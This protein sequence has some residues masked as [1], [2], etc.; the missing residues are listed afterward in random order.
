MKGKYV[1]IAVFVLFSTLLFFLFPALYSVADN[2][3]PTVT[4]ITPSSGITGTVVDVTN[5]EG[6]GFWG[7]PEVKIAR[8]IASISTG[9]DYTIGVLDEG[10]VEAVGDNSNGQ[11]NVSGWTGIKAIS[12]KG[13]NTVGLK[14]DG[15]VVA[16]GQNYYNRNKIY[17]W[18]GISAVSAGG[19]H[20]VGLRNDGTVVA[21]GDNA[22]G[23][24]NVS[25]WTDIIAVSSGFYHT[26]GL[27]EDGTVVAVGHNTYG[28][29]NVSSWTDIIA[30]SSGIYNTVGLK[31]DGTAVAVGWNNYGQCNVSSW[32][33]ITAV[34]AGG[35][36]TI[37]LKGDGTAVAVG[38]NNYGQCDISGWTDIMAVSSGFFHT[39]GLKEDGTVLA[40]G[41]NV[42]GQCN[43]SG[44]TKYLNA[45]DVAVLSPTQITCTLDLMGAETGPW[46]VV[47]ANED[48]KSGTL[49]G[50]FDIEHPAPTVTGID[51]GDGNNDETVHILNLTGTNFRDKATVRITRTGQADITATSVNVVSDTQITCDLDLTGAQIGQWKVVVLNDDGKDGSLDNGFTVEYH[52][53]AISS[54]TPDHGDIT[55]ITS[56]T[57]LHGSGFMIG[58]TVRLTR[59]GQ[60]DIVADFVTVVSDI[61]ITCDLDLTG[62]ELGLWNVVVENNDGMS[63]I[64]TNGFFA[65]G[66]SLGAWGQNDGGQ[67]NFPRGNDYRAIEAG[68]NHSLALKEDGSLV[69][70]GSNNYGQCNVPAGIYKAAAAGPANN[71]AI[72]SDGSLVGWGFNMAGQCT[73]PAGYDYVAVTAGGNHSV[74]IKADGSLV[75]WGD[76][77]LGQGNCPS[78]NDYVA[79]AAGWDFTVAL[80]SG[81][82]LVAWG[83]NYHGQASAPPG[84]DYTDVAA[85]DHFGVALK[86]D[87]SLVAWGYNDNQEC[88][89]PAGND[90][91]DIDAGYNHGLALRSDGSLVAWGLNNYGQCDVPTGNYFLDVSAGG[92]QCLV[93][94]NYPAPTVTGVNPD[95]GNNDQTVHIDNL[96]GTNFRNGAIAKLT[97]AGQ[98]DITA[99]NVVVVSD[100]Q[101]TCDL[102]L[103]GAA[104]GQWN[105]VVENDD[106]RVGTDTDCFTVEYNSLIVTSITPDHAYNDGAISITDL[107]GS[108]FMTGATV[109]LTMSDQPDII[110]NPVTVVSDNQITCDL[111]LTWVQGGQWNIVVTNEDGKSGSLENGFTVE[112]LAPTLT[113][114]TPSSGIVGT[115]VDINNLEGT[116]FWGN[117]IVKLRTAIK[118]VAAGGFCTVGL[119]ADG[120]VVAVG[121]NNYGQCNVSGWKNIVAVSTGGYHTVGLKADGTV[122]TV[123]DNSQ[124]QRNVSSW[125]GIVAIA[126]GY[127][128]TVGLRSDGTVVAVGKSSSGQCNVSSWENITAVSAGTDHTLGLKVDGT[129]VAAGSNY[130][131]QCNVSGWM[132]ITAVSAGSYHTVG[133][134]ADGTVLAVGMNYES[135]CNVSGWTNITAISAGSMHTAGLK[136]DGTVVAVGYNGYN[137]LNVYGFTTDID[138]TDVV[139]QSHTQITCALDLTGAALGP[140][141]VVVINE[142]GK[143][144]VL[145]NGFTVAEYPAPSVVSITP[146]NGATGTTV[147]ITDLVGSDFRENATVKLRKDII[148]VAAGYYHTVGLKTDSTVVA[149]GENSSGQCNVSS[150]ANIAAVSAGNSHTVGLKKDGTVV[151]VGSNG[152]GQCNVTGWSHITAVSAGYSYTLGLKED[153]TVLAVGRND[154]GQCEVSSWTDIVAISAGYYHAVGLKAD[155]TVVAAGNNDSGQRNVSEWSGI[156]AI[157]AGGG[158]TVG[159]KSDG[160]VVA[161]GGNG[162]GQCNVAVWTNIAAISAGG[163]HTVG[164]KADNTVVAVGWDSYG[165]CNVSGLMYDIDA[166][167]VVVHSDT[168]ITCRFDLT[169]ALAGPWNVVVINEDGK[170]GLLDDG[171][172]VEYPA[173][174][175]TGITP[176]KGNNNGPIHIDNLSGTDFRTGVIVKL[177][178]QDQLD[179]VDADP[180]V[181]SDTKLT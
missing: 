14:V 70:W 95:Y 82:S 102:D 150:W 128:H 35:E 44:W 12:T 155:G 29:C 8:T 118:A 61:Q 146:S 90:Y 113:S 53:P 57:D 9:N 72:K 94:A 67:C 18:T 88:V 1:S 123:G 173:P 181:V 148:A 33:D 119:K 152:L 7:N 153:G 145:Y 107:H 105:V 175:V 62:A 30:V 149:V 59:S 116:G 51:P 78:G 163:S 156:I 73:V 109:K 132:G 93:I 97:K 15:T 16:A 144:G 38:W 139:V 135:Q 58:A 104:L 75:A 69:A 157:S 74:A 162:D 112:Y 137:Q 79:I 27:K 11:C 101:I 49:V 3:A 117:P 160:T 171:F 176:N 166:T 34:S 126:A 39:V 65:G 52:A 115:T 60:P 127:Q 37:G 25:A 56:I 142:D 6:T 36:H 43:V 110:A 31:A 141:S 179:I 40:V 22:Y 41:S 45:T 100:V 120:S 169:G 13:S 21:V 77:S 71:L 111:D 165:Q 177:T 50:G 86:S 129:V 159:L 143:A 5:L 81:G 19:L 172:S 85:G 10:V 48:G 32:T 26:A 138:A 140:W 20:T 158:H 122:V 76:N 42:Y 83:P 89:V 167:D 151:A 4:A 133:L 168:R 17:D 136:S 131:G 174:T 66:R 164:L 154:Y 106:G 134:K 84:S 46:S 124:G 64:L 108:G 92:N 130:Y 103:Y 2:P 125:T 91:V 47:V 99:T 68:A 54:I 80:R 28:Q 121:Q 178:K 114:I 96:V 23:Q 180:T 98:A 161:V 147:D 55:G 87:G 63:G 170:S 24:C